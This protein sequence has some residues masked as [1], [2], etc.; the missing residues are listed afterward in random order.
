M[1]WP[2]PVTTASTLE[3]NLEGKKKNKRKE[4]SL[5]RIRNK[6]AIFLFIRLAFIAQPRFLSRP[7]P[8][9]QLSKVNSLYSPQSAMTMQLH[10]VGPPL[11]LAGFGPPSWW[12]ETSNNIKLHFGG[13][14]DSVAVSVVPPPETTTTTPPSPPTGSCCARGATSTSQ[15]GLGTG[16]VGEL[17]LNQPICD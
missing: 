2:L 14:G 7:P 17:L 12:R 10:V 6:A 1:W 11:G 15:P 4:K 3:N 8:G 13:R 5:R 16:R 9:F